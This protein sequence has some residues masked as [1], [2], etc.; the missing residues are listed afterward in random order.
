MVKTKDDPT[1][2]VSPAPIIEGENAAVHLVHGECQR[3]GDWLTT[4]CGIAVEPS[5]QRT[6]CVLSGERREL[7]AEC[8]ARVLATDG[9]C[10]LCGELA[11]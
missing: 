4:W 2:G 11:A 10:P 3:N 8:V 1:T 9:V 7:C 6:E 5:G